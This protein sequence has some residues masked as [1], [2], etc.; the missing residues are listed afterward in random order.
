MVSKDVGHLRLKTHTNTCTYALTISLND[1][2]FWVTCSIQ[3]FLTQGPY[4]QAYNNLSSCFESL[5]CFTTW[6]KNK[7]ADILKFSITSF[8]RK[9][10]YFPLNSTQV[11]LSGSLDNTLRPVRICSG[12]NLVPNRHHAI[13]II[14]DLDQWSIHSSQNLN[15]LGQTT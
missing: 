15:K 13:C 12:N 2:N 5:L 4:Y 8:W 1:K 10:L 9:L 11:L 3:Q 6:I 7:M 14:G